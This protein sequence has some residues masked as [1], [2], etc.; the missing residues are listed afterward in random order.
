MYTD[1]IKKLK[2]YKTGFYERKS[3][4]AEDRQIAS[5]GDQRASNN[6]TAKRY[7]LRVSKKNIFN[8]AMSAKQPGRPEFNRMVEAI[9]KGDVQVIVSWHANR[10]ARN[11][12]DAGRIIQLLSDG[13]LKAII[14]P[15]KTFFNNGAD[16][17][18]LYLDFGQSQKYSKD[19]SDVVKRGMYSKVKRGFWPGRPKVGYVNVRIA[20][21]ESKQVIDKER[22]LLL[23]KAVDLLLTGNYS[24]S[25]VL[26][27][28]NNEWGFRSRKTKRTG[29]TPLSATKFYDLLKD[30]FY[31]GVIEW[32]G[33]EGTVHPSVPRLLTEEEFWKIQEALGDKGKPRPQ[34]YMNLPFRATFKC[35]ECNSN[36]FPYARSKKMKSG[37]VKNYEYIRCGCDKHVRKCNQKQT[38]VKE[39][40]EQI[41]EILNTITI[42]QS[43]CDW[44]TKW[45]RE[46]HKGEVEEQNQILVNWEKA[47]EGAQSR[48]ARLVDMYMDGL[49]DN[50]KEFNAKKKQVEA[51]EKEARKELK[52]MQERTS[53]WMDLA[54][55][56][57]TFA[58]N[59]KYNFEH[60]TAED[61]TAILKSLGSNFT[62]YNGNVLVDLEKPFIEFKNNCEIVNAELKA[63]EPSELVAVG[64]NNKVFEDWFLKWSG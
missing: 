58:A 49:I 23:R 11:G 54:I 31:Y 25:Q 61:K 44:A 42:S 46:E 7:G 41:L 59:A 30:P 48:K 64:A 27:R 26:D 24:G 33:A 62:I 2:K 15:H 47:I 16:I 8:E 39:I 52:R 57:F 35:G 6:E 53:N 12:L 37:S 40:E 60:G 50:K 22:F 55:N 36:W 10:I 5:L 29:G 9:E 21:E 19:L 45:I 28:I 14:T 63:L 4:D 20:G 18:M 1:N 17:F 56:T 32:G 34:K 38:S 43:F 13:E 51:E 3:Q